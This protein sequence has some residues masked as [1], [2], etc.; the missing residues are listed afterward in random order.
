MYTFFKPDAQCLTSAFI[1]M[2]ALRS[3]RQERRKLRIQQVREQ[4]QQLAAA[5]TER[6]RQHKQQMQ[7][8]AAAAQKVD[9]F[10]DVVHRLESKRFR[11]HVYAAALFHTSRCA[12]DTDVNVVL[13]KQVL[14]A[15]ERKEEKK[16]LEELYQTSMSY[17]GSGHE[18]ARELQESAADTQ[19]Q[20]DQSRQHKRVSTFFNATDPS[21]HLVFEIDILCSRK[22]A[23]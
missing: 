10:V 9:S 3:E 13:L 15:I 20:I 2:E 7:A 8:Q 4:E 16:S 22:D 19:Y 14:N 12:L 23:L 5:T 11:F 1:Q 17:F 21:R 18:A 6:I